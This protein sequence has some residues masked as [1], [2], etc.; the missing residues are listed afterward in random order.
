MRREMVSN[1]SGSDRVNQSQAARLPRDKS[2]CQACD[3]AI[4]FDVNRR[5]VFSGE[6]R[7]IAS[8]TP[9]CCSG[10]KIKALADHHAATYRSILR[11]ISFLD[12]L[13]IRG[14]RAIPIAVA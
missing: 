8:L 5:C 14:N 2:W 12:D 6:N 10:N 1:L 9:I 7:K 13:L 4:L 11:E 3:L